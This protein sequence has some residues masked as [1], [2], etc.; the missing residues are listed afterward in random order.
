MTPLEWIG[1]AN[2]IVIPALTWV[3][4]KFLRPKMENSELKSVLDMGIR[5]VE[6]ISARGNLKGQTKEDL[7]AE[8]G[9]TFK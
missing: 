7:W 5:A 6:E 8:F 2:L 1:I 9:T 3:W 4:K